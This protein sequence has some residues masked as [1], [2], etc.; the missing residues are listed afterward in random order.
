MDLS[1]AL[2]KL[3]QRGFRF[4]S[5]EMFP[6][7]VGIERD[8]FV[9]LVEPTPEGGLGPLRASGYLLGGRIAV[10]VERGGRSFF[11]AKQQEVP[12]TEAMLEAYGRF[13]KELRQILV[14]SAAGEE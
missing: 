13:Q 7:A 8:N 3:L 2:E 4:R 11:Q 6:R 14:G 5:L 9:A 12:A 10:L 1:Q